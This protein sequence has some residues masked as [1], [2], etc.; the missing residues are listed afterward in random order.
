MKKLQYVLDSLIIDWKEN[1]R[2]VLFSAFLAFVGVFF[3]ANINKI[4][5][6]VEIFSFMQDTCFLSLNNENYPLDQL[7]S[8]EQEIGFIL[9]SAECVGINLDDKYAECYIYDDYMLEQINYVLSEGRKSQNDN[10]ILLSANLKEKYQIGDVVVISG[11]NKKNEYIE[12]EKVVSG[13][14]KYNTIFYSHGAGDKLYDL[15]IVDIGQGEDYLYGLDAVICTDQDF[16]VMDTMVQKGTY[17]VE[18]QRESDYKTLQEKVTDIGYLY[19]GQELIDQNQK[20][21][22][23][24]RNQKK[25]FVIAGLSLGISIFM[26]SIYISI[27]RRRKELGVMMLTGATFRCAQFLMRIPGIIS[28]ITGSVLGVCTVVYVINRNILEGEWYWYHILIVIALIVLLYIL[29][30]MIL[31]WLWKRKNIID[32]IERG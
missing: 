32:L 5:N 31:T 3:A 23:Y 2:L 14:L 21:L 27:M 6:D 16:A 8:L 25:I 1:F 10:E 29:C 15:M 30:C 17:M 20:T 7:L 24:E 28:V 22:R 4:V 9:H 19:S 12:K 13:F 18:L 11:Y 26:G